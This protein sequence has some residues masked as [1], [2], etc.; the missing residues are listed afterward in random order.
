MRNWKTTLAGVLAALGVAA[1][2]LTGGPLGA[3]DLG[4]LAAAVGLLV[5]KDHNVTGGTVRQ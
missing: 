3:E 4:V 5:A 1:K 2:L